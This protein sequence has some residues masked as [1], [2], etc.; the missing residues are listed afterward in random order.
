MRNLLLTL[1]LFSGTFATAQNFSGI[2][3]CINPGHGGHDSDDRFIGETGYWESEGNLT[4][5]LYLRD[6]LESWGAEIVLTRTQ[7]RTQDDLP[8]SQISQIANDNEVDFFHSIH[9]NAN[10][11]KVNYPL[12]LFRGY[13][14]DPVFPESK[15]MSRIMWNYLYETNR[16]YWAGNS[17]NIRGDWDFYDW[18]TQG[19]GAL[20]RLEMPGVLSE[21][22]HHDYP[23]EAWR[24][25]NIEY[26]KHEAWAFARTFIEY[27]NKT[28]YTKGIVAGI[29][30]D[31]WQTTDYYF[32]PNSDDE[33]L[34]LNQIKVTLLP[35]GRE[36]FG[37]EFNNGFFMF[38][39][40]LP[41]DYM[42]IYEVEDYFTDT[43]NVTVLANK[44][45]FADAYLQF[46]TTMVPAVVDYS[47]GKAND[48][49]DAATT[50]HIKFDLPMDSISVAEA[51]G[52]EPTSL[53]VFKWNEDKT[54]VQ[55]V[56]NQPLDKSTTYKVSLTADASQKWGIPIGQPFEFEFATKNRNRLSLIEYYP[57]NNQTDVNTK[58]QIRYHFDAELSQASLIGNFRLLDELWVTLKSWFVFP[59][60]EQFFPDIQEE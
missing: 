56:P 51:L 6:I 58:C 19:L 39:N 55:Y 22:S 11:Q 21:G 18:G 1:L 46:D 45:T 26:R 49:I 60:Q 27:F 13:D 32:E 43:A 16:G 17:E 24:L 36:Y 28:P 8:L 57:L 54:E 38:E 20:R 53:G 47:P 9:S 34:P 10:N 33:I 44:T 48:S 15:E 35:E 5:A 42:L 12:M 25:Q 50:I 52:F 40:L 41:G 31:P 30:R 4:K 2:K 7:N 59:F 14:N 29:V 37:D 23:I 3:L